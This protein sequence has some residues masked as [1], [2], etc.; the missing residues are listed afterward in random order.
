MWSTPRPTTRGPAAF[1]A[2]V[3]PPRL[4]RWTEAPAS[5]GSREA[6]AEYT[7]ADFLSRVR[8]MTF[9]GRRAGEGYFSADGKKMV[10]QS[11]REEGNPFFQIYEVDLETGDKLDAKGIEKTFVGFCQKYRPPSA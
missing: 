8:R 2:F 3:S 1:A 4:T 6:R 7:E 10:F 5:A 11:E 9:A